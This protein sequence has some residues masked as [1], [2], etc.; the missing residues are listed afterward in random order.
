MGHGDAENVVR[1]GATGS[2]PHKF[3]GCERGSRMKTEFSVLSVKF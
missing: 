3:G 2:G 1:V